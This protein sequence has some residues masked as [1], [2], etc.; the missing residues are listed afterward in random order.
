MTKEEVL[1]KISVILGLKRTLTE[2]E[3][4]KNYELVA[5]MKE[6]KKNLGLMEK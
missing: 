4:E 6:S 5:D 3:L 1:Q 2:T